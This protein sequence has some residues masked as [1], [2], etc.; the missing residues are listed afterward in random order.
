MHFLQA[1]RI[2]NGTHFLEEAAVI[3][4]SEKQELIEIINAADVE[5]GK[6][7][8]LKGIIT[9]GFVNAHCHT[10]LSHL[11]NKIPEKTGL[12]GFGKQ[13]IFQRMSQNQP[14][15]KEK[16]LQADNE[17]WEHG[18]VAVGD[19][20]NTADSFEMKA[21][22]NIHYHTFVELL[23][24]HP[25]KAEGSFEYGIKL[26]NQLKE[27]NLAGSLAPHAPYST[28]LELIEMISGFNIKNNLPSSIHNQES[29]EETKFF[30]G[31]SGGFN[32]LYAFLQMDLSW[33]QPPMKSSLNYYLDSLHSQ[34]TILVHNTFTS[35]ED[36]EKAKS[37]NVYWCFC[38]SANLYIEGRLPV[39]NFFIE[40]KEKICLGTDSLASNH[41]LSIIKE[42]N[43]VLKNS[44]F[45]LEDVLKSMTSIPAAALNL[46]RFGNLKIGKNA[47]LNLIELKEN[48]IHFI[49]TLNS[50]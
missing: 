12:P 19:I 20:S 50:L 44:N 6:I 32:E 17:M 49:K 35:K 34:Q 27:K 41:E 3:V 10:E 37:K 18:I 16:I 7:Q 9:P 24:L 8:K 39:F 29:E 36:I 5:A 47:G 46:H 33:F 14:D 25:Q 48:Q 30:Y 1:D 4:I 45:T 43:H 13:I 21:G 15:I 28:S 11:K 26:L 38:P 42:A 40:E 23:G 22:S 31:K 2:F